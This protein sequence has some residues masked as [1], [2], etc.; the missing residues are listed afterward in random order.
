MRTR[1]VHPLVHHRLSVTKLQTED[2]LL[3]K[4]SMPAMTAH[5]SCAW[6]TVAEPLQQALA[7]AEKDGS[8]IAQMICPRCAGP[9]IGRVSLVVPG[10]A[11]YKGKDNRP[12][13]RES[14]S[15]QTKTFYCECGLRH[16]GKP[17]HEL[18]AGCGAYWQ[19]IL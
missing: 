6:S 7:T 1:S 18:A 11:G 16:R 19:V 12:S 17:D 2:V 3:Q 4:G 14:L 13:L 5:K 8:L 15:G 10:S 9:T